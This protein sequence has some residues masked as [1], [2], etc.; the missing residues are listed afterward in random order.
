M[1][2]L[3]RCLLVLTFIAIA[4]L[5]FAHETTGWKTPEEAKKLKNSIKATDA[6]IQK[7]KEIYE[8]NCARCHGIKGDGKGTVTGLNP[9]PTNFKESPGEAVTDGEFF[10]KMSTG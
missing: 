3:L 8:K 2:R 4:A 10:W 9:K 7:G 5:A 6:S 1:Y